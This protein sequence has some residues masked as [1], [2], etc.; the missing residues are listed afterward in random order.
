MIYRTLGRTGYKV[1]ALGLGGFQL[2]GFFGV[3]PEEADHIIDYAIAHGINLIDTAAAYGFG[4]GEAIVGR[5][6]LRHPTDRPYVCAKVGHLHELIS[7][8]R[9]D[10][11]FQDPDEIMRNIK[12]SMWVMRIDCFDMLLIHEL[13][14]QWKANYDTGDCV[15]QEVLE[16]CKRD[17]LTKYIGAASWDYNA[18]ARMI[19]TDRIDVVLSAGGI[20]LL[21]R[22]I[23]DELIPAAVEHNVGVMVGGCL[24]QN[25]PGLV[26][27]KRAA[28]EKFLKS[29]DPK[30]AM[31][32]RKL[33]ALYDL[34][35]EQ[36]LNM[37]QMAVRYVLSNENVHCDP[38]GAR[39]VAHVAD[40]VRSA[41]M[42]VLPPDVVEKIHAIQDMGESYDGLELATKVRTEHIFDV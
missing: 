10:A 12:H 35:D 5:A 9:G 25:N 7:R 17:G 33:L 21:S 1:S 13:E 19:R 40:N 34:A 30:L 32:G 26:T 36:G 31:L 42:G 2:T 6:L 11:A 8:A 15:V 16:Q 29:D 14:R 41:E 27:Q 23:C 22:P 24:G 38:M 4:E 20:S 28:C 39:E 37:I 3:S 18:L